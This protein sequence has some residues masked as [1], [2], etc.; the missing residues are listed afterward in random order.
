MSSGLGTLLALAATLAIGC[1]TATRS[2]SADR[3]LIE[4]EP[5]GAAIF[6]NEV[7]SGTTPQMVSMPRDHAIK[8]RCSLAEHR[9]NTET[10]YRETASATAF[11]GPLF[12]VVDAITGAAYPLQ[13]RRLFVELT[14]LAAPK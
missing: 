8:V 1:A 12:A 5:S 6:V 4:S 11:D 10:V 13:R 9:D 3:L 7:F 14:P 2:R